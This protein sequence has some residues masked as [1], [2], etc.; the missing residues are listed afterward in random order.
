MG[1]SVNNYLG[2]YKAKFT[3]VHTRI[4]NFNI[5]FRVYRRPFKRGHEIKIFRFFLSELTESINHIM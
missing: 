2:N 4:A 1:T 5:W 3:F